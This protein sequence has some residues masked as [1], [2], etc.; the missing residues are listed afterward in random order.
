MWR[1]LKNNLSDLDK[2]EILELIGLQSR[3]N[4]AERIVPTIAL[5]GAGVLVGVGLGLMLAPKPGKALRGELRDR[6]TKGP[7]GSHTQPPK[8]SKDAVTHP[9]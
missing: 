6:L 9:A 2:D 8:V 3:R 1:S 4:T 7:N 5:F